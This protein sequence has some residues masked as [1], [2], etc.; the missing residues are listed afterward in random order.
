[1][2]IIRWVNACA[3]GNFCNLLKEISEKDAHK[4]AFRSKY[5][6]VL[7]VQYAKASLVKI[8]TEQYLE[9]R[10]QFQDFKLKF[11]LN[12]PKDSA[13]YSIISIAA[14]RGSKSVM[15]E[16]LGH[17]FSVHL[18]LHHSVMNTNHLEKAEIEETKQMIEFILLKHP[19]LVHEKNEFGQTALHF[20]NLHIDLIM[21][22]IDLGVDVHAT[23]ENLENIL[24]CCPHYMTPEEYGKLVKHLSSSVDSKIFHSI[25]KRRNTPLHWA[26]NCLEVLDST[27]DIFL[28]AEVDFNAYSVEYTPLLLAVVTYRSE[29]LLSSL[30]RVGADIDKRGEYNRTVLH[31]AAEFGNLIAVRFFIPRNCDV[32]ALDE[33]NNTPLYLALEF[34]KTN[35]GNC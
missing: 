3:I 18:V 9:Q 32:D 7:A 2:F 12:Q 16:L 21:I 1:M 33:T 15:E 23:D 31:Y 20:P 22:L 8:V 24:H 14:L 11:D 35:T 5:P 28:S 30:I 26:V 17:K 27:F 4:R 29:R 19:S 25:D 13:F 34:S 10:S 6:V